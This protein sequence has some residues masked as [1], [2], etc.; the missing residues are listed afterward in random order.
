MEEPLNVNEAA[1][2]LGLKPG[3]VYNMISRRTIPFHK[4][5][6]RVLFRQAE[7]EAWFQSTLVPCVPRPGDSGKKVQ[8]SNA[9]VEAITNNAVEQ[10]C[11]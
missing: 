11:R 8:Q 3:T 4:I 10:F 1:M 9:D 2:F 5:G 7:L 6:R